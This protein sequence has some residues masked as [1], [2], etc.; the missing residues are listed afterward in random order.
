MGAL[1]YGSS[2]ATDTV[3]H[4]VYLPFSEEQLLR[5]F[6]P[7]GGR[8]GPDEAERHLTYYRESLRRLAEFETGPPPAAKDAR[9]V[10]RRARQIEKDE[11]FWVA[12]ALMGVFHAGDRIARLAELLGRA[13]GPAP[14]LDGLDS[15]EAALDGRL[16]LFFEVSL[17]S[18]PAYRAWLRDHLAERA[19]IPYVREAAAGSRLEGATHVDAL[20]LA[21]DTGFAVLFEA[22]VLSDVDGQ[23]SFDVMRNQLARNIDVMLDANPGLAPPLTKRDPE[24]TCFV[25]LT[26]ELFK[27]HPH[28]RLYGWLLPEYRRDASALARDLTH[29]EP[30]GVDWRAL[31]ARLGWLTFEDC[32]RVAPGSCRWIVEVTA[33]EP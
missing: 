26:P 20:L 2:M 17:P 15:W 25:L 6:A 1:S 12:A 8:V 5:H 14:P 22:K 7:V 24:R 19:M 18:P 9:A 29:R 16:H 4:P 32:E 21:E 33:E 10:V 3:L 11:R 13:L 31:A 28:S 23:V 27:R 30:Q